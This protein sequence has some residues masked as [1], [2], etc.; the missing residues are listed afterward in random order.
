[1]SSERYGDMDLVFWL[2]RSINAM[3][4]EELQTALGE[5]MM[6]IENLRAKAAY[7]QGM[8]KINEKHNSRFTN[9]EYIDSFC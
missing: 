2:G 8:Y 9:P 7:W 1:M 6:Q 4:R 5:A 3:T